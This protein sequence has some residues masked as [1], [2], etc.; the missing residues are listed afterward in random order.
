MHDISDE[1]LLQSPQSHVSELEVDTGLDVF[2]EGEMLSTILTGRLPR[3]H[4]RLGS[5]QGTTRVGKIGSHLREPGLRQSFHSR[6]NTF[7]A[8]NATLLH[9]MKEGFSLLTVCF[10]FICD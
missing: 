3:A 5:A 9:E 10:L 6:A 4:M 1:W 2:S 7:H 8:G